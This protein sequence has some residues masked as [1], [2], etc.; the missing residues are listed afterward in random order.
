MWR[1]VRGQVH[2]L[3]HS[4]ETELVALDVLHIEA[5][6]VLLIGKQQLPANRAER[7]QTCAFSLERGQTLFTHKPGA[8]PHIKMHPILD[9]LAFGNTLEEQ[10]RAHT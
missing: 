7:D 3:G 8:D 1:E 6:L 9:D 10:S 2:G 5:R 4:V